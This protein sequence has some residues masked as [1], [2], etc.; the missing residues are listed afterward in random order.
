MVVL[1]YNI[2]SQKPKAEN[3]ES[4]ANLGYKSLVILQEKKEGRNYF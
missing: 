3:Y 1:A 2:S 4:W